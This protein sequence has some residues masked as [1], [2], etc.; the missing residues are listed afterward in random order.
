MKGEAGKENLPENAC[1]SHISGISLV[2]KS[3][4][5]N[6]GSGNWFL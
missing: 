6:S 3:S 4:Y 5:G 1:C 2:K